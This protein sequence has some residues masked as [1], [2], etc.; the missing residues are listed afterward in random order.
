MFFIFVENSLTKIIFKSI[1]FYMSN[2]RILSFKCDK[3][4]LSFELPKFHKKEEIQNFSHYN[5]HFYF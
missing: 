1:S 5:D 2:L 4:H 3:F